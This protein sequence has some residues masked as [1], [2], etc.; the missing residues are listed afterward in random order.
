MVHLEK[1]SGKNVWEILKLRV[2]EDQREFVAS[3]ETSI[4]EAYIA[5]NEHGH[6]FPF[7]IY[8]DET[9]VGFCMVGYGTDDSWTDAPAVAANSYNLWRLMIDER[10]QGKG[11]GK[12]AMQQILAF[13]RTMPVQESDLC[14]LSYE[15]ENLAARS[16]Y[17]SFGFRETGERDGEEV[18]AIL[19]L[20]ES[21]EVSVQPDESAS[22]PAASLLDLL[23]SVDK[24]SPLEEK[25]QLYMDLFH[26]REDVYARRWENTTKGTSGYSPACNNEWIRGICQKPCKTCHNAD[27]IPFTAKAV[28]S[29]L[30]RTDP[31]VLGIYAL[32]PDETCWFLAIDLD[33]STWQE[34]VRALRNTCRQE[35]IPVAVEKS[36]SGNGAHLWF[37]FSE[38]IPASMARRFGTS[39]ISAAMKSDAKLSF[40][41]YDRMFP[42]QD[43]MPKGGFGNLIA[44]PLQPEAAR[45]CGG[46]LFIDEQGI[47][48]ADQWHF[49]SEMQKLSRIDLEAILS[50]IGSNPLGP[51]V[52][53][54]EE[55]KPWERSSESRIP[56]DDP[57]TTLD[58]TIAD[59]IYI[60]TE[61]VSNAVLNQLKRLAAF[62]NPAFYQMQA[63]RMP[64]WN[65]PRVISCASYE[66]SYLCLPRG[67]EEAV[68]ALAKAHQISIRWQ[69]HQADGRPISLSFNG[70]LYP[71]QQIAFDVLSQHD[72]G[73]LSAT[74]A[75]GKTV[76]GAA[77]IAQKGTST[78]I[79]VHRTQLM[80][81]WKER[82][83][84]FL[85][86][87]ETLPEAPKNRGRKKVMSLIGTYGS[88][89]NSRSGIIDIAMMQSIE[90][91]G[92]IPDWIGEYGLVIVDE[93]HHLPAV[94]F[95][96]ILKK[97]RA[98]YTYGLTATPR[99]KD[100]HDPIITMYLGPIR[101]KVDAREQ[102]QLR[103]F[104]HVMVPRFTGMTFP[105]EP[106][107]EPMQIGNYYNAIADDDLRN[108]MIV[109]DVFSCLDEGRNCLVLS[110]RVRH[111]RKLA[112][113]IGARGQTVFTLV[114]GLSAAESA[115]QL[116][117]LRAWPHDQPVVVCATGKYIGE[118]FDESRLDTLFLTMPISWEGILAQYA[119]RLHRLYQGKTEVRVYDYIDDQAAMLERMYHKRLK[120]YSALGY[121][122]CGDRAD[123]Y[124]TRDVIYDQNTFVEPFLADIREARRSLI[125]V[126]PFIRKQR[127]TWIYKAIGENPRPLKVTVITRPSEA[128][129]GQA[130]SEVYEAIQA[131]EQLG[132]EVIFRKGIHQ[133]FA[134]ID[135]RV[136]WYGSI[137]LLS[138]GTAQES[139]IRIITGTVAETLLKTVR[140]K[141][142]QNA[143]S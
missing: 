27:Y 86:I 96:S 62:R 102:A 129:S 69:D 61:N 85:D 77:L 89:K 81:Q 59:R 66:D 26:G 14:W 24:S 138:F 46:S 45:A 1:V 6:A 19:N 12:A 28:Q 132:C 4:I 109:D 7:G 123:A 116:Q 139:I 92:V 87:H 95:E 105:A 15:P 88:G 97:V 68:N 143:P 30:S 141:P 112:E 84:D 70:S 9:P 44:L 8:D 124:L 37:F 79:L 40:R 108:G 72:K 71:E 5:Q 75:F 21:P 115:E 65:T 29:H 114:G 137:N 20:N 82:L 2:R 54:E 122:V 53:T 130:S 136:V 35:Q 76:I 113:L 134:V 100:G 140:P 99:R 23:R 11:Y 34:D 119:G 107:N 133:K 39:L 42:N 33:E 56:E 38:K 118:G 74:T 120:T 83:E 55:K 121:Q 60:S 90:R 13:I 104:T 127:I 41:S 51:L 111:V 106:G 22:A 94:S 131:L 48:Y 128:F 126:S 36:R 101:Y 80:E 31:A 78:L 142:Y 16:L 110:E 10:Y 49:L 43:S 25:I 50:R 93:C 57:T 58:C 135:R 32:Q 52:E 3:N 117:K 18:I 98:R 125:I 103:P 67:C 47:A 91:K 17:Q 73:V 64:V 63:M